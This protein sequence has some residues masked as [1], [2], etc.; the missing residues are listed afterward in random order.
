MKISIVSVCVIVFLF[1]FLLP[2]ASAACPLGYTPMTT[3]TTYPYGPYGTIYVESSPP[4]AIVFVNGVNH[5]HSPATITNLYQGTYT[6]KAELAGLELRIHPL[7]LP[8]PGP[9]SR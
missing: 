6:I 5:G 2:S 1:F 4:G 3:T 9:A 8:C 7:S